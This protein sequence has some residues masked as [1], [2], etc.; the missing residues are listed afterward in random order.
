M[1]PD[2]KTYCFRI[3]FCLFFLIGSNAHGLLLAEDSLKY[4]PGHYLAVNQ[5]HDLNGF[6]FLD[7]PTVVGISK[8][9]NWG[10]LEP[11]S[12]IYDFSEI[13]HDLN[14]LEQ[15]N[16]K[17]LVFFIEKSFDGSEIMPEYLSEYTIV[18]EKIVISNRWHPYIV[19]RMLLLADTLASLIDDSESFEG[20]AIQESALS[21]SKEALNENNYTPEA[22]RGAL[23]ETLNGLSER[24]TTSRV[25]WY[26]NFFPGKQEYLYEVIDKVNYDNLVICGPDILP[27]RIGLERI[28]YPVYFHY[29]GKIPLGCS[30]QWSGYQHHKNDTTIKDEPLHPEGYIPMEE[31]YKFG[32]DSL[33]L[34]Y[35]FW[36][37]IPYL[38]GGKNTIYDAM[39]RSK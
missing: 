16:K 5:Y 14:L 39:E 25:F 15:H 9:Y 33:K 11:D 23:V 3:Y 7:E 24:F 10:N 2:S 19:E 38:S 4:N 1:I 28:T 32:R 34:N 35:I 17:L 22:Y 29:Y 36:Q 26:M 21:L 37:Y 12:G 30:V 20:I 31:I 27:Y 13:L 8:R 18:D 6:E